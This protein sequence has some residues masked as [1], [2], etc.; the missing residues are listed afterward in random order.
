MNGPTKDQAMIITGESGAGK[1]F[2]TGKVLSFIDAI[3]RFASGKKS[4]TE[5]NSM[6]TKVMATMPIMDAFGN[7]CMPRN[8]DSSRFGKLYKI[9][10]DKSNKTVTGASIETYLLEKS[11]VCEQQSW[12]RNFHV[13]YQLLFYANSNAASAHATRKHWSKQLKLMRPMDYHYLNRFLGG[14]RQARGEDLAMEEGSSVCQFK[15]C[16]RH[17]HE[18][19]G[20][21]EDRGVDDAA[22]FE[23][24]GNA[25]KETLPA[26][27]ANGFSETQILEIF[28]IV[29]GV[30]L[31]GNVMF[32]PENQKPSL[33]H[34]RITSQHSSRI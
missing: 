3:N 21:F 13:F 19:S 2:T 18:D 23:S 4:N 26:L 11:R 24:K 12:E 1:T 30:L 7:A 28:S 22:V 10:F 8:D 14:K 9:Y 5:E 6:T 16:D 15:I 25:A 27:V 32:N 17:S 29:S 20:I 33:E 31:L 34:L